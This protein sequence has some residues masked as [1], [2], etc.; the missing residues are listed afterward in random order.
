[1]VASPPLAQEF[2]GSNLGNGMADIF[3]NQI[4]ND[5]IGW[6]VEIIQACDRGDYQ[7]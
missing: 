6:V 3:I 5:Y 1:M 2:P 7:I 4:F